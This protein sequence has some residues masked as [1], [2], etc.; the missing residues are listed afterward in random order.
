MNSR[1][2]LVS[3]LFSA[4]RCARPPRGVVVKIGNRRHAVGQEHRK[5][6]VDEV[7]VP[8]DQAGQN[9]PAVETHD[10]G[11]ARNR[12]L[13]S[14]SD[15]LD[16]I[17]LDDHDSVSDRRLARTVDQR[18]AFEHE[19][20]VLSR[21]RPG[22]EQERDE[23]E[24]DPRF[25]VCLTFSVDRVERLRLRGLADVDRLCSCGG[26]CGCALQPGHRERIGPI[27]SNFDREPPL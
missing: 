21:G 6:P 15:R 16:A 8:V 9:R 19:H 4:A 3:P 23:N 10:V 13:S 12:Y 14:A 2:P 1:G 18:S 20:A 11:V 17:A 24:R 22:G 7:C 26:R 25:H 5:V 27:A